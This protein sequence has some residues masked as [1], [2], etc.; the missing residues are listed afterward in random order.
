M[1][2]LIYAAFGLEVAV[3]T[4]GDHQ[5]IRWS[6]Q[7]KWVEERDADNGLRTLLEKL[8][9]SL[10]AGTQLEIDLQDLSSSNTS[11]IGYI[12][13]T[14]GSALLH[15]CR[16]IVRYRTDIR[17]QKNLMQ[18]ISCRVEPAMKTNFQL[19]ECQAAGPT[20]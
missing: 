4:L 18:A 20:G 13:Q 12:A 2:E 16:V 15:R 1:S 9:T 6:G 3:T 11:T 7:S 5:R 10:Q 19:V 17:F 14:V 8:A